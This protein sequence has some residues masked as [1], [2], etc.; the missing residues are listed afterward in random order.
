MTP[1]PRA[2]VVIAGA[3][4]VGLTLA[5]GL[6]RQGASVHLFEKR[7]AFGM[8][9]KMERCNARTME[10]F[11]RLGIE[12]EIRDAGLDNDM[13][14]DV[15]ICLEDVNRPPL[16]TH[17]YASVNELKRSYRSTHDGTTAAVPYQLI[18]QYTLEPLLCE[19][20]RRYPSVQITFDRELT[21]FTQTE[22]AVQ[23]ELR[24]ASGEGWEIDADYLVGCDGGASTVR[25]LLG[26]TL[27]GETLL[28]MRQALFRSDELLDRIPIGKGRHYHIADDKNS[29]LIVQDDKQHFSLHATVS[30]DE[31][32][33]P[34]F[35]KIIGFPI[36]Y[37]TLYVGGW[38]QR[39][40]LANRYRDRRVFLAGDSAHLV[41]PTGGLGMNTGHG[42]AVDLA[43]KLAAV[44]GGWGG[45]GLLDSYEAE[46]RPTGRR[47]IAASRRAAK[48]RRQWRD[49]W[50]PEIADESAAGERARADLRE[51]AEREQRWSND[52]YGIELGYRY[53]ASPVLAYDAAPDSEDQPVEFEYSPSTLV[54]ARLPNVWLRDGRPLQDEFG[55]EFTLIDT[56][57]SGA[58]ASELA[59]AF[60]R[61]G[62][63]F[64]SIRP[65]S[66]HAA[67]V[68]GEGLLL[69]RPDLHIAWSGDACP[70]DAQGLAMRLTGRYPASTAR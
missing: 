60:E 37:E 48:G 56:T 39:L 59:A 8:L 58:D 47:N 52:L 11:R 46:R 61:L 36:D 29:F 38:Q 42:D 49:M 22:D 55:F 45:P 14:M 21:D 3:G 10:N 9:P 40:M 16:V 66:D 43:W 57:P 1:L 65:D 51:V 67:R 7:P 69:I 70:E 18:S 50:R 17:E 64:R 27:E 19:I 32:M 2:D 41:I 33:P 28:A 24:S 13:P 5:I 4:P 34:L 6:A 15:F 44:V 63:P 26:F 23:V 62:A 30:S 20:A 53:M 68:Y 12:D 54:G 35:E 31:E 25:D